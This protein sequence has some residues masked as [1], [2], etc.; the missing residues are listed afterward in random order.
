MQNTGGKSMTKRE[1]LERALN[2]QAGPVP[3]DIGGTS[4]TGIHVSMVWKSGK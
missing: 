2:H 3:F 4:V 1:K